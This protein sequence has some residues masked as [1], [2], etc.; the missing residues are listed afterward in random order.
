MVFSDSKT[1]LGLTPE[2]AGVIV[3]IFALFFAWLGYRQL[4]KS[5]GDTEAPCSA[6]SLRESQCARGFRRTQYFNLNLEIQYHLDK[7]S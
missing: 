2:W 5:K 3:S 1:F 4:I 6:E 7:F